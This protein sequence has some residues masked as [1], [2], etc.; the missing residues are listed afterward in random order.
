MNTIDMWLPSSNGHAEHGLVTGFLF[1][2]QG[3]IAP[4]ATIAS[5]F[6]ILALYGVPVREP[7]QHLIAVVF[8]LAFL[9]FRDMTT[10]RQQLTGAAVRARAGDLVYAW[11]ALIGLLLFIAYATKSSA[12][13]SRVVLFTW[14]LLTPLQ[15]LVAQ[16]AFQR[17]QL[18][19]MR[20]ALS[21]RKVVIVG[22]T[23]LSCRLAE[24]LIEDPCLHADFC[25]FFDDRAAE[26]IGP[27]DSGKILGRL[28]GLPQYVATHRIDTI[29]IALPIRHRAATSELLDSLHDTT[30]SIY[31]VPDIFVFDLIQARMDD[32]NGIPVMALCET[33]FVG[34]SGFIKRISD[35]V[36]AAIVLLVSMPLFLVI[37]IGIKSTSEGPVF[38]RQRRYGLDGE[39][40]LVYKFRTMCVTEDGD[41]VTQTSRNDPR[42]TRF[43]VFIRRW[44]LDELPQFLNV[45]N[46]TMSIVGPRP[47]AVAHNEMY[48]KLI[49]GYMVRHKAMPGITGLAQVNG[50]RGATDTVE[51]MRARVEL[52]LNYLRNWSLGLDFRIMLKT[53]GVVIAGTRAY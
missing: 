18:A 14:F 44:S 51:A 12:D 16:V 27:V 19:A 43:G 35:V 52:D 22:V 37:A 34:V 40:F 33:P 1:L 48:R 8:P 26:R 24:Q 13:F 21:P 41:D 30:A 38:F 32:I 9:V 46:G 11:F 36:I 23:D 7:Y 50:F 6:I 4:V 25:G 47:H 20:R 49:K 53:I 3:L 10:T 2:I 39:E 17:L 42:V 45:L 28:A 15:I 5:L 29:Y 31:F